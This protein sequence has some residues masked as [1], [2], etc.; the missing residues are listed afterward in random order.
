M[1]NQRF[2][3]LL[4]GALSHPLLPFRL[5][6]LALALKFVVD[7]CGAKG[8]QALESWCAARDAQ[9]VGL[10]GVTPL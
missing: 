3:Q 9:D 8:E 2:E 6:R 4:N 5:T 1:K 7:E 10:D